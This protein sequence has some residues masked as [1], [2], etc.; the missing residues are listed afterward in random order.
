MK[1]QP[2]LKTSE[3]AAALG[4]KTA[5]VYQWLRVGLIPDP[6]R[7]VTGYRQWTAA[8]IESIRQFWASRKRG[9]VAA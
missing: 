5:C 8:D 3:V 4:V 1:D 6:P 7:S 9:K 2:F